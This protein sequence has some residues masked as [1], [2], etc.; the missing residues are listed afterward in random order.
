MKK[1]PRQNKNQNHNG[2]AKRNSRW[3]LL[4]IC[5]TLPIIAWRLAGPAWE[6]LFPKKDTQT[7][8]TSTATEVYN[9]KKEV[10][11]WEARLFTG[12]SDHVLGEIMEISLEMADLSGVSIKEKRMHTQMTAPDGWKRVGITITGEGSFQEL[13]SFLNLLTFYEKY[14]AVDRLQVHTQTRRKRLGEEV[15]LEEP[16]LNFQMIISTLQ[17]VK[18]L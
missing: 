16:S 2:D 5:L 7:S 9:L 11:Q 8:A 12:P 1:K 4:V 13:V 3:P 18:P 6:G 14:L 15:A 10:R 17:V